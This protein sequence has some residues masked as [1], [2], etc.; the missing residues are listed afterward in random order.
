MTPYAYFIEAYQK[1]GKK[2]LFIT[3]D[4]KNDARAEREV[5]N[6]LDDNE[7][8]V[9]RGTDYK[10]PVRTHYP[11]FD[12]LPEDGVLDDTWCDRNVLEED[13]LTWQKIPSAE[14]SSI[15]IQNDHA[16]VTSQQKKTVPDGFIAI[17][18][19]TFNQRVLAGW[20]FGSFSSDD[21]LAQSQ[22]L[23]INM[24]Q[25]DMDATYAQ[26]VLLALNNARELLQLQHC[27]IE[28]LFDLI[29]SIKSIWPLNGASPSVGSIV[30][31]AKEWINAHNN[32][33]ESSNGPL[34]EDITAKWVAKQGIKR[35]NAGT[36]A[37]GNNQTDRGND[38]THSLD[39][40]NKEIAMATL[41]MDFDIYEIPGPILRRAK[42]IIANKEE[43]FNTWSQKL[44]NMPGILD[45]SR[46]AIFALIRNAIPDITKMPASMQPYINSS[47][48]ESNHAH[49]S[50]ELLT[51][52]RHLPAITE[53]GNTTETNNGTDSTLENTKLG[54]TDAQPEMKNLGGGMFSID[55]LSQKATSNE[56]EKP[57]N[58]SE[59]V[60]DVQMETNVGQS[61]EAV[62]S[63]P[64]TTNEHGTVE[65]AAANLANA[66][67]RCTDAIPSVQKIEPRN[68][69]ENIPARTNSEHVEKLEA[70]IARLEGVLA[71]FAAAFTTAEDT[72]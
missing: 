46:A 22:V 44:L 4:A 58:H 42:E 41:P 40:L 60:G 26:N 61:S 38:I 37:G 34:R 71:S 2:N 9:G 18:D 28:T 64:P 25:H 65:E 54:S 21:L 11:V 31:F 67:K 35:T 43:P 55:G 13:G 30:T 19:A 1:S 72:L 7:I 16:A 24:L 17:E 14:P 68:I 45:F 59:E 49:P 36:N 27:Y 15:N 47:L 69:A 39:F 63:L 62:T 29:D 57:E 66:M 6:I 52:A 10:N 53:P 32:Q 48:T 51:L 23:E 20:L 3:L 56:G 70:R 50:L 8:A 5:L 12:D 33:S